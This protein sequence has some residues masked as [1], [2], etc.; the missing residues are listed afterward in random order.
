MPP[1]TVAPDAAIQTLLTD[2]K[3][4][5]NELQAFLASEKL[6][7]VSDDPDAAKQSQNDAAV[8]DIDDN[9]SP[10]LLTWESYQD[11]DPQGGSSCPI[12][13]SIDVNTLADTKLKPAMLNAL[14]AAV[15]ARQIFITTRLSQ[16]SDNLG[17]V[18][19]DYSSG[20][21]IATA[22]L[23]GER[24]RLIELRLNLMNG[25]L[26]LV[27]GLTKAIAA[28]GQVKLSNI[29]A[30]LAYAPVIT[31]SSISSKTN[32]TVYVSVKDA[33]VFSVKDVVYIS[34]KNKPEVQ[35]SIVDI[36]GNRLEFAKP[37]PQGYSLDNLGRVY[38]DLT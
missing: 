6:N 22:G 31:V 3:D 13:N 17:S 20:E 19:Q 12:F 9:I 24:F 21:I 14:K 15:Q 28:Q 32:G 7:I 36:V 4:R 23:Y 33:S 30:G 27:T 35:T 34:A 10:A 1:D 37:I 25:S 18:T 11:F 29:N 38:K 8:D 5:V 16:L 2:L 26:N